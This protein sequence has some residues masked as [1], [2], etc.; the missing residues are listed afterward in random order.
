MAREV[1]RIAGWI[2]RWAR[3]V[4]VE[5]LEM[6]LPPPGVIAILEEDAFV[7]ELNCYGTAL[8]VP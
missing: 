5:E 2:A 4:G 8:G 7:A 3:S 6:R 1:N